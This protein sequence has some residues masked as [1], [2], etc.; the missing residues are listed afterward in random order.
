MK[1]A[2]FIKT[3]NLGDAVV[4][5]ASIA[6]I[7]DHY[8]VHIICF[9]DCAP[10][11]ETLPGVQKVWSVRRGDRGWVSVLSGIRLLLRLTK[12]RF[13]VLAQ[14]SDDW[15][16]ALLSRILRPEVS[17][18]HNRPR[19]VGFWTRSF[20]YLAPITPRRHAA[21]QDLDLLRRVGLYSGEASAYILPPSFRLDPRAAELLSILGLKK[22]DF[23]VLHLFS[24][25]SFKQLSTDTC[26][27]VI[28]RLTGEGRRVLITGDGQDLTKFQDLKLVAIPNLYTA[29]G[30]SIETFSSLLNNCSAVLS[31]DSFALHLASALQK[32]TLAIFG[33]SGEDN[34]RP[35]KTSHIVLEQRDQYPCRPCGRDGCGG[36]KVSQCLST[37]SSDNILRFFN[38]LI[39]K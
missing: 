23:V 35:W 30:E 16:G 5:T 10:I 36:S 4:L 9:S 39:K 15:R 24:R 11:Y 1:T 19:R 6:A 25:W 7:S 20:K 3:K 37:M 34:W 8:K 27:Q 32:P 2:L 38:L 12:W 13:D 29:F 21:E 22:D 33:P 26:R 17:V 14:F 18:A 28:L 31:I